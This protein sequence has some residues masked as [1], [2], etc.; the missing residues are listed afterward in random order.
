LTGSAKGPVIAARTVLS[1]QDSRLLR[2]YAKIEI[3]ANPGPGSSG[4]TGQQMTAE[5]R[6]MPPGYFIYGFAGVELFA[7][8]ATRSNEFSGDTLAASARKEETATVLGGGLKFAPN[9]DPATW[10]FIVWSKSGAGAATVNAVDVC[11]QDDCKSYPQCPADCP[12]K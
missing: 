12:T 11:K 4:P 1:E 8:L 6:E 3:I 10:R 2:D 9:G 5:A 7:G